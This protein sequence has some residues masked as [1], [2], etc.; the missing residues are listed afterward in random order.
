MSSPDEVE[1]EMKASKAVEAVE[2]VEGCLDP[3]SG[4]LKILNSSAAAVL[5]PGLHRLRCQVL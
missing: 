1:M 5:G 3:I 4:C 2:A